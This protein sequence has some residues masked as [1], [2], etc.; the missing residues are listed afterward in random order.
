MMNEVFINRHFSNFLNKHENIILNIFD[1]LKTFKNDIPNTY[2]YSYKYPPKRNNF[3]YTDKLYIGCILYITLN[4][5]SWLSFIGPIEG[6]QVHKRFREYCKYNLFE[7]TFNTT[8]DKYLN[9]NS[10]NLLLTDTTNI[11]NKQSVEVT[12]KNPYHKNKRSI[13]VSA[14]TDGYGIPLNINVYDG[15]MHDSKCIIKDIDDITKNNTINDK[16]IKMNEKITMIADKGYD[17]KNIRRL[18]RKKRIIPLIKPNNR[19]TRDE[20][21]KRSLN[22][23]Q[24]KI[25]KKRI[26]VEHFFGIIKKYPKI[27]SVYEKTIKSY[28]NLLFIVSSMLIANIIR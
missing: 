3:K 15:N 10:F 25:Y 1:T 11:Y 9:G 21:K 14:I 18:L 19:N 22:V 4:N 26:K 2:K 16:I 5:R 12:N 20:S 28:T 27:N 7:D 13:K 6:K 24:E 17:S 23:N 8:I